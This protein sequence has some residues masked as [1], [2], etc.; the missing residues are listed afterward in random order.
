MNYEAERNFMVKKH[1]AA[2]GIRDTR[3]LAAMRSVPRHE[4]VHEQ[5]QDNA[6]ADHPLPI[7]RGQTISQPYIVALMT[8]LLELQGDEKVLEIG[9]GSGY[10][11]AI[12]AELAAEV[13]SLER[14]DQLSAVASMRLAQYDNLRLIKGNGAQGY[15]QAAPYDAIIVT[16]AVKELSSVFI[17]Q[18]TCDGVLVIPVGDHEQNLLKIRKN[19]VKYEQKLICSVRFVPLIDAD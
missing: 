8:E 1:I 3:V 12:L 14:I 4:F 10:Q 5:L 13:F 17:E 2:R 19:Q 18:L 6:Y 16:A 9:T 7:G 11:T 15:L